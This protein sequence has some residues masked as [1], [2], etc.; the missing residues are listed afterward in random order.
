MT[1]RAFAG[2]S[3]AAGLAAAPA[4]AAADGKFFRVE[5]RKGHWW[6]ITPSGEPFFSVAMNHIDSTTLRY[7]ENSSIW[8]ERYGNSEERWIRTGVRRNLLDWGFNSVGWTQEV[9]TRTP[10]NHRHS[11][12]WGLEQYQWLDMPPNLAFPYCHLLPFAETHQWEVET[13]LPDFFSKDWEQWC[14]YVARDSCQRMKDDPKLIGYFYVELSGVG[15][16]N[17]PRWP[18]DITK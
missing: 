4:A 9:V 6:F 12:P 17:S 13:R 11:R 5:K 1:R 7:E 8:R 18:P 10:T 2:V 15:A 14:D 16:K 3:A